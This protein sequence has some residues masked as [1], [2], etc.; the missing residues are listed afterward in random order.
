[1]AAFLA[2]LPSGESRVNLKDFYDRQS[3]PNYDP[4]KLGYLDD[5]SSFDR[6]LDCPTEPQ[7]YVTGHP[8]QP[9]PRMTPAP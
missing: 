5:L 1:M 6:L 7:P 3:R 4:M 9:L 2:A 8:L